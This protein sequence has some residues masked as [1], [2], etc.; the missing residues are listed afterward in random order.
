M[1]ANHRMHN[2][3]YLLLV[4]VSLLDAFELLYYNFVA[5]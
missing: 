5:K 1:H 3:S 4:T 2:L